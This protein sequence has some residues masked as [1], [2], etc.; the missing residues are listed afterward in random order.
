MSSSPRE[1][2]FEERVCSVP[3]VVDVAL[4]EVAVPVVE[5][6]GRRQRQLR[7]VEVAVGSREAVAVVVAVGVRQ[8]DEPVVDL[9]EQ[10]APRRAA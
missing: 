7:R 10:L 6:A 5:L 8:P 2:R 1:V 4:E 9:T 3:I